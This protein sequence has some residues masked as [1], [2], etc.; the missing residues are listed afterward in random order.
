MVSAYLTGVQLYALKR[1]VGVVTEAWLRITS[2]NV[3]GT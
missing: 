1:Y 3:V 2:S